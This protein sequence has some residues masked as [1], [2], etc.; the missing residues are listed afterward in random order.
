M[1]D[2]GIGVMGAYDAMQFAFLSFVSYE[3]KT[4]GGTVLL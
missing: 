1:A 3:E 2:L 4:A